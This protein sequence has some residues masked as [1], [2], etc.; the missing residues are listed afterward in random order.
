MRHR[1]HLIMSETQGTDVPCSGQP[2]DN[3]ETY[4]LRL[5]SP[6]WSGALTSER[7]RYK[8]LSLVDFPYTVNGRQTSPVYRF[9]DLEFVHRRRNRP[10]M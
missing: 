8:V 6:F 10:P 4:L 3:T 2:Y 1:K 5:V 7:W 9:K